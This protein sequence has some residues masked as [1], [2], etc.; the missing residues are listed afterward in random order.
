[1]SI[2]YAQSPGG[3]KFPY[4]IGISVGE[5]NKQW[6]NDI[7]LKAQPEDLQDFSNYGIYIFKLQNGNLYKLGS[8][9]ILKRQVLNRYIV[10]FMTK[11]EFNN[12]SPETM[13]SNEL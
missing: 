6:T 11:E 1:M 3:M 9:E 7:R 4:Q 10:Y 12:W 5:F 13:A 2:T 8:D